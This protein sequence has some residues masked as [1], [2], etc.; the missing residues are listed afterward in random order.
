MTQRNDVLDYSS[1]ADV[2][3]ESNL[4]GVVYSPHKRLSQVAERAESE[5]SG[6]NVSS[7]DPSLDDWQEDS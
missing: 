1:G 6:L 4:Q 2:Q 3:S 5:W 7:R